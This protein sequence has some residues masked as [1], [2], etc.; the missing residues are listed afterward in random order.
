MSPERG[1]QPR[2]KNAMYASYS[3]VQYFGTELPVRGFP[4]ADGRYEASMIN[5]P[6]L[7]Q[8]LPVLPFEKLAQSRSPRA[9][10][11]EIF[12]TAV[13]A[14]LIDGQAC[15]SDRPSPFGL[16]ETGAADRLRTGEELL[17]DA[18][19]RA[20]CLGDIPV[21]VDP[22]E[23]SRTLLAMYIGLDVLARSHTEE[24]ARRSILRQV[25]AMLS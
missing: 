15:G 12:E 7:R 3:V 4:A 8:V 10:L 11:L 22:Q 23:T 17:R 14:H 25:E 18:I 21:H 2:S 20:Q 24:N 9:T 13:R 19:L 16:H 1:L 5:D 6:E